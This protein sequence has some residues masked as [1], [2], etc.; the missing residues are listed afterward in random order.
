MGKIIG[1]DLGTTNSVVA[2]M[3]GDA[4]AVIVN[5]E[6]QRTTPSVVAFTKDGERLV[7]VAARRQAVTNAEQTVFSAKRLIGSKFDESAKE[8]GR[9]PYEVVRADNGDCRIRVAGQG[10]LPARDQRDGAAE[11]QGA[12]RGLPGTAGHRGGHHRPRLLQRQPAPG[13]QGRRPHRRPRGQAHHQRAHRGRPRLRHA[14]EVGRDHRR[15][16]PRRRHLRHLHPRGRRER[17]R[18]PVHQRRHPPRWRRLRPGPHRLAHRDLQ[19][20]HRHRRLQP[21]DGAPAPQGSRREGQDRAVLL[22]QHADQP[23]LPHRRCLRPQAPRRH[24]LA[25]RL[26]AHDRSARRSAPSAP[27][28]RRSTM[29]ASRPPTSTR[30]SSSVA[31]RASR[32]CS[33]RSRSSSARRPTAP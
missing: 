22:G 32:W 19:E 28:R 10:L 13:H 18:G 7:G 23:A 14:E 20:G 31:P 3:D 2:V 15:V 29:P 21:D 6:G 4:A 17:R 26:R 16:R 12:G 30:S 8:I 11:A 24:A 27:A 5:D 33:R 9:L 25:R 1:I